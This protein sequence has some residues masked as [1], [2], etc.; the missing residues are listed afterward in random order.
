M[1]KCCQDSSDDALIQERGD[2]QS[3][4]EKLD[5]VAA[6]TPDCNRPL[7]ACRLRLYPPA[8]MRRNP[9]LQSHMR[10]NA[11]IL[12][13]A[14]P[15][16]DDNV[17]LERK[18]LVR[19][20]IT[21]S[22]NVQAV[23]PVIAAQV[24]P[25]MIG[26]ELMSYLVGFEGAARLHSPDNCLFMKSNVEKAFRNGHLILLPLNHDLPIRRWKVML[27]S[28]SA[29]D[30]NYLRRDGE[31]FLRDLDGKEVAFR[32]EHRPASRFLYF[33]YVVTLLRCKGERRHGWKELWDRLSTMNPWPMSGQ[34]LRKS[35]LVTLGREVADIE[36]DEML[37]L[38]EGQSFTDAHSLTSEEEEEV[39][40]R[41]KQ[42]YLENARAISSDDEDDE[43]PCED[44]SDET[45]SDEE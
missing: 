42:A 6:L 31:G 38:T 24:V 13:G 16:K 1:L 23:M 7:T 5:L 34:Y 36:E 14:R 29:M 8:Q 25:T 9:T 40:R 35:M 32:T 37:R 26:F 43:E 17:A 21:G 12:Y 11:I 33:H 15:T 4:G 2:L 20:C 3:F 41:V 18:D 39:V 27:T 19:C 45:R 28:K 22:F 30:T 44:D 10:A